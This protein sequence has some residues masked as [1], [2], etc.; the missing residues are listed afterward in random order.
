MKRFK[1]SSQGFC[2][3]GIYCVDGLAVQLVP[4]ATIGEHELC[5]GCFKVVAKLLVSN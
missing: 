2:Q 4:V 1:A 5:K 3:A